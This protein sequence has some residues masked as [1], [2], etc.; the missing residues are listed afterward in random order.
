MPNGNQQKG[1]H[2]SMQLQ[3]AQ[4]WRALIGKFGMLCFFLVLLAVLDG[5][6][7]KFFEPTNVF[8]VLPGEEVA[9]N[10]PLPE[11]IKQTEQLTFQSDAAGLTVTFDTIH[12]GYFL[13]GNMW[14]G[15]LA[16]GADLT[17]GK[18]TVSIRPRDYPPEKPA[19]QLRVVVHPDVLS[20][21]SG[22]YSFLK[23]HTGYSPYLF[24]AA[25]LPGIA[26]AMGAV[27]FLSKR[28]DAL[29]AAQG[30]AEIY[31]AKRHE[32]VWRLSF[33]M[34]SRHGLAVGDRITV[35]DP[36]GKYIGT[37][38]VTEIMDTDATA[39]VAGE[40]L[41]RPGYFASRTST[42]GTDHRFRK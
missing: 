31:Y 15:R 37:G 6:V 34:G 7:A 17:P 33:G 11:D 25:L 35:L 3:Q 20:Q 42:A 8:H 2:Q 14:R 12:S 41:I 23:R 13:G 38:Q 22:S 1:W 9:V 5:V 29:E 27:L 21:R 39:L 18:Y 36:R 32:G 28:I 26:L 40:Q 19:Y 30:L 10:G 24:A 16:V 4:R